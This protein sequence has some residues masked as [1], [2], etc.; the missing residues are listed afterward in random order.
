MPKTLKHTFI[1]APDISLP[2]DFQLLAVRPVDPVWPG[3]SVILA[4]SEGKNEYATWK[5][6]HD[7]ADCDSGNYF[8]ASKDDS[9]FSKAFENFQTR[10]IVPPA[11]GGLFVLN[12]KQI[13]TIS[14]GLKQEVISRTD[15]NRQTDDEQLIDENNLAIRGAKRLYAD[16]NGEEM[17]V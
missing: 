16:L 5:Y 17:A 10:N 4:F 15:E 7:F 13:A 11:G 12:D 14:E 2:L 1:K 3:F 6:G 9:A 8:P